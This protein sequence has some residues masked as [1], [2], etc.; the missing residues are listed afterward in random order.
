MSHLKTDV[1]LGLRSILWL[2]GFGGHSG[3]K[4]LGYGAWMVLCT[5]LSIL[6]RGVCRCFGDLI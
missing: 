3:C 6:G 5:G 1:N 4:S 2:L